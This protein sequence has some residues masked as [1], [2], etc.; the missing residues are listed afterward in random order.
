MRILIVEDDTLFASTLGRNLKTTEPDY[1]VFVANSIKDA[2]KIIYSAKPAID[3]ILVDRDMRPG[4]GMQ[5]LQDLRRDHRDLDA[6]VITGRADLETGLAAS[7]L[8][9]H[10]FEKPLGINELVVTL[11]EVRHHRSTQHERD[12]LKVLAEVAEEVQRKQTVNQVADTVVRY[13]RRLGFERARLWLVGDDGKTLTGLSQIGNAGMDDFRG[14]RFAFEELP[15]SG[16]ALESGHPE[17]FAG[18][19]LGQSA[20]ETLYADRGWP[21]PVGQW[22]ELPLLGAGRRIGV[23]ALTTT[24]STRAR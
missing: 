22:A 11:R 7:S 20:M 14:R 4:D 13:A 5:L 10:Y 3:V 12:W 19:D 17:V 6:I 21:A 24:R 9:A 2:R 23:L 15:Y 16:K 8:G 1:E 18:R